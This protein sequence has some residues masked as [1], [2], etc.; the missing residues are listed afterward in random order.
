[1]EDTIRVSVKQ[2]LAQRL[3]KVVH[4]VTEALGVKRRGRERLADDLIDAAHMLDAYAQRR[5]VS[6]GA[7]AQED[8]VWGARWRVGPWREEFLAQRLDDPQAQEFLTM[9]SSVFAQDRDAARWGDDVVE[10]RQDLSTFL[11]VEPM[12]R[13]PEGDE[14]GWS[15]SG[16]ERLGVASAEG[17]GQRARCRSFS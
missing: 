15:I 1:M 3:L 8:L 14:R 13:A 17:D 5:Q 12:K 16:G 6:E 11:G 7:A 4:T 2:P 9:A 10:L